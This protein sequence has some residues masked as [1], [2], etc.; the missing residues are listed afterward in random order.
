NDANTLISGLTG[1]KIRWNE[2]NKAFELS[3]EKLIGNTILVTTFLSYCAPLKQD[4]RQRTLNEWQKQI[5][6]RTI[7]FSDNFNIIEQLN[8]EATIGE[9]NLQGLP[10]DDLSIQN[11]IIATSNY[12]YP[13]LIDR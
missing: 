3:I 9:W 6:Q 12:R 8:D 4:F 5:Q 7:H 2:Q 11:G 1:E 10:N 13:L